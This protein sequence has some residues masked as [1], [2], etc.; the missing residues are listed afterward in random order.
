MKVTDEESLKKRLRD[1]QKLLSP[2][3]KRRFG[4]MIYDKKIKSL[5]SKDGKNR[6]RF[7]EQY[8]IPFDGRVIQGIYGSV[9]IEFNR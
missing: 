2:G 6:L 9:V 3:T 4:A 8:E 7:Y 1:A 5:I